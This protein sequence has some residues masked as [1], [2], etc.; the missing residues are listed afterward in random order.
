MT[1]FTQRTFL[2]TCSFA[3]VGLCHPAGAA[4]DGESL[5]DGKS[6]KDTNESM[7]LLRS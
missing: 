1:S 4:S 2:K 7:R 6:L 5:F 3:S